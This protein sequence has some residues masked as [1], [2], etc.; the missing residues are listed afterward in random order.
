MSDSKLRHS[1][2][3]LRQ[4]QVLNLQVEMFKTIESTSATTLY[5]VLIYIQL[6]YYSYGKDPKMPLK[7]NL[8]A[9]IFQIFPEGHAPRPLA[10]ACFAC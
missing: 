10:L 7:F 1:Y 5:V 3:S 9:S 4:L 8:R 6:A 2:I